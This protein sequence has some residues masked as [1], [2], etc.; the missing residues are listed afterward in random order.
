MLSVN[1]RRYVGKGVTTKRNFQQ[2]SWGSHWMWHTS[3][4]NFLRTLLLHFQG[5]QTLKAL[6][7]FLYKSIS[8]KLSCHKNLRQNTALDQEHVKRASWLMCTWL[9][10]PV[11]GEVKA[12]IK[13]S[14]VVVFGVLSRMVVVRGSWDAPFLLESQSNSRTS[15]ETGW[16]RPTRWGFLCKMSLKAPFRSYKST[17]DRDCIASNRMSSRTFEINIILRIDLFSGSL[18]N[19]DEAKSAERS[20]EEENHP[21]H[22][23]VTIL[24]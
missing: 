22:F 17:D 6:C 5:T 19:E 8:A 15:T 23:T 20:L 3:S 4:A 2:V 7:I 24:T 1:C 18:F 13:I 9:P 10:F 21:L 11:K 14:P 16:L 12:K